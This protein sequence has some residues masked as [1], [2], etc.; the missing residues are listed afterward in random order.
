[1]AA[2]SKNPGILLRSV[3]DLQGLAATAGRGSMDHRSGYWV[4]GSH[5]GDGGCFC[6]AGCTGRSSR[7]M[8]SK[9]LL[10]VERVW[11]PVSGFATLVLYILKDV[12]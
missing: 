7:N 10:K 2:D 1:M 11:L 6:G 5:C 12:I 8:K 3:P 9:R 4:S